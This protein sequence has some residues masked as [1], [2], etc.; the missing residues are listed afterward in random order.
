MRKPRLRESENLPS[1]HQ[2]EDLNLGPHLN[3]VEPP[4]GVSKLKQMAKYK[5]TKMLKVSS[6]LEKE[7]MEDFT[8]LQLFF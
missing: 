3:S 5:G 1:A 2:S 8:S 7:L 4:Q 6:Q